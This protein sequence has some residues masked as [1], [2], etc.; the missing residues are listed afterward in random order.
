MIASLR[1]RRVIAGI[2]L[3]LAAACGSSS[4]SSPTSI[5]IEGNWSGTWSFVTSGVTVTDNVTV[6]FTQP[7]NANGTWN[8][9]NGAAG[10][11]QFAVASTVTGTM[12]I[13][14]TRIGGGLCSATGNLTGTVSSTAMTLNVPS[15]PTTTQCNW[16]TNNQFSLHR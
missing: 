11:F 15:L 14:Q 12:V 5:S 7:S 2:C 6:T 3:T 10:T 1:T 4:P 13:N 8:A 16:A 9:D